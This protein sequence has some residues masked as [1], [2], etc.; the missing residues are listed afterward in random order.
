MK[1]VN[2]NKTL[3][4]GLTLGLLYSNTVTSAK[5]ISKDTV[6]KKIVTPTFDIG[7]GT[8]LMTGDT[9][10][11]IG[12]LLTSYDGSS[13]Q[14]HFPVSAL[15]WPLDIWLAR[16]SMGMDIGE[17]WRVNGEI[18]KNI[19]DPGDQ[20]I[21]KDWLTISNPKQLDAYS[22]S[23]ISNFSAFMLDINA[24]WTFLEHQDGTV[25]VGFGLKSQKFKYDG[26]LVHQYSPS[27]NPEIN[28]GYGDGRVGITYEMTYTMPYLRIGTDFKI[29]PNFTVEGSLDYS[30]IVTAGDEDHH[31]MRKGNRV[32]KGDM[33]GNA[34][35][36]NMA[37][38]YNFLNSWSIKAGFN[39]TK[40]SVDGDM[41][42]S[43]YGYSL[44]TEHEESKSAQTSGYL[45]VGYKF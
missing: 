38:T 27:G 41:D 3:M 34:Y 43:Q 14:V 42:V 26:K 9:T 20:M 7:F 12:G 31:L 17:S 24:E 19:G 13:F 2:K 33:S 5:N 39:Y 44:L 30:P 18:K 40:I 16:F 15:E 45:T 1:Q 23:N 37:G 35:M 8:E 11:S 21:D 32:A 22:N 36:L 25:Y 10:Y 29:T 28:E 4:L 6:S